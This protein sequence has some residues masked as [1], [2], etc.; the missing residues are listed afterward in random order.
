MKAQKNYKY[1]FSRDT[2]ELFV[3]SNQKRLE[4]EDKYKLSLTEINN[5]NYKNNLLLVKDSIQDNIIHS[6]DTTLLIRNNKII[7]LQ[8]DIDK[9][10]KAIKI[11][12]VLIILTLVIGLII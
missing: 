2:L 8:D 9:K 1:C 7:G 11:Y 6:K 12:K 5:I 4:L 3:K 10:D